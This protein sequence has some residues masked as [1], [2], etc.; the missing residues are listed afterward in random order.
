MW[1][2]LLVQTELTIH[3]LRQATLNPRMSAWEYYNE[4]FDYSAT[5]LGPLGFKIMIH[6]TSNKRKYWDQR[7]QEGFSEGPA[8]HDA[9]PIFKTPETTGFRSL[10]DRKSVV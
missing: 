6:N 3:I 10:E 5:P 9:L 7:G 4:A 2:N 1:D 8:L